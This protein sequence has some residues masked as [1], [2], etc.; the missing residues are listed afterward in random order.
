MS[1]Q[2]FH[3]TGALPID[4][5]SGHHAAG[6]VDVVLTE[7]EAAHLLRTGAVT[8][9]AAPAMVAEADVAGTSGLSEQKPLS[10]R[11]EQ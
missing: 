10:K 8:P 3:V 4:V 11:K 7:A 2:K 6:A 9:M 5:R 1:T